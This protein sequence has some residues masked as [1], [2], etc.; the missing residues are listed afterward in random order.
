MPAYNEEESILVAVANVR[1]A[2]E[3][4][5]GDS[6]IIVVD[7]GSTDGTSA[8]LDAMAAAGQVRVIHSPTNRGYGWAVRAGCAAATRPLLFLTDSDDQF[9]PMELALL[10]PLINEA[11][12]VVGHRVG[13]RDGTLRAALSTGYNALVRALLDVRVRDINCAFK[14]VRREAFGRLALLSPGYI[15]NAEMM[16]RA[17]RARLRVREVPVSHRRR[18]AGSSKVGIADVP[19]SLA[20]LLA[21][22]R[23]LHETPPD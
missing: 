18:R 2:L 20:E 15:I 23:V 21:L 19:L 13:R 17:A 6:E 8:R 7:D 10:L 3:R 12:I 14:L 9:D 16:A 11:D 1:Q 22:R 4:L 5:T